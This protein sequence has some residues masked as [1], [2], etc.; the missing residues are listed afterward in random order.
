MSLRKRCQP[1]RLSH[2]ASAGIYLLKNVSYVLS[3]AQFTAQEARTASLPIYHMITLCAFA[4]VFLHTSIMVRTLK[5]LI[6]YL[7][8]QLHEARV[9][10][11]SVTP[12]LAVA[13]CQ[14]THQLRVALRSGSQALLCFLMWCS[15]SNCHLTPRRR[16]FRSPIYHRQTV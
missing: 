1:H 5:S 6:Y 2:L 13:D 11:C 4:K 16:L 7:L 15:Q 10:S 12:T 3:F 14:S 8:V 9:D